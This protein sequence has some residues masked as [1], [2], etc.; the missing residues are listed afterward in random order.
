MLA[1][2]EFLD[3]DG[4]PINGKELRG[5]ERAAADARS[6]LG[7]DPTSEAKLRLTQAA[8]AAQ[9]VDLDAIRARG[10]A[11]LEGRGDRLPDA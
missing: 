5:F 9:V 7:L 11:A 10:R 8:A 1:A 2:A 6:R 4:K 3:D